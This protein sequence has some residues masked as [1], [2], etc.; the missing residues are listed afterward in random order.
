[1]WLQDKE[2]GSL[3]MKIALNELKFYK[4]KY[5][6]ITFIVVL[7]ASMVL[8]ISG[9]AKGLARENVSLIDQFK[10]EQFVIQK[11][12]DNQIQR[13][14]ISPEQQTEIE[15]I[16]KTA[17]FKASMATAQYKDANSD[18]LFGSMPKNEQPSLKSGDYPQNNHEVVLNSKLE[19]EGLNIGDTIKI[20]GKDQEFKITGF[21]NHAM[22]AHTDFAL[23]TEKG[24]D[25]VTDNHTP[26]SM[27]FLKGL[28]DTQIQNLK[29]IKD[30]K[31]VTQKDLTDGI[32]SYQAEQ[33]PLTMMI[34][35]LFVITAIVLTAFFYVM[36]IQ[37]TSEIGILKAIGIK[38]G[39]LL[40]SLLFQILFVT[41][42]GVGFALG[43]ITALSLIMPVTMPFHLTS[44]LMLIMVVVFIAVAIIGALL[45][46]VRVL[47]VD[48]IEA[49]GGGN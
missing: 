20:K 11:D 22:Y 35:S 2:K 36:T 43:I 34:V 12:A 16:V 13:S 37:K 45:S 49:I 30:V 47:K 25:Q 23:V 21:F 31:V 32:P 8:F 14:N 7:L 10:S 27:Y 28:S 33:A 26:T 19:G 42:L 1:M 46:L 6:L 9:L 5:L 3:I 29:D 39:H 4:F 40:G 24:L 18:L 44:N 41:L 38:T 17:P 48:P 15:K